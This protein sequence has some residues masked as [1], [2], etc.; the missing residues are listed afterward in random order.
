MYISPCRSICRLDVRTGVCIG[1]GRTKKEISEWPT[2][3][4]YQR[5]KIMERLGYGKR[6]GIRTGGK[7]VSSRM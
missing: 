6:K 5:R 3:H 2:Y 1:C 7:R 4:Y